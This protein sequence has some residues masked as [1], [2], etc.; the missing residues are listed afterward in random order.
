M[1]VKK[2]PDQ[3]VVFKS[4]CAIVKKSPKFRQAADPCHPE[5]YIHTFQI[6][7]PNY[8]IEGKKFGQR[9]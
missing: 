9:R 3:L 1:K 6:Y 5:C 7:V 2:A 8:K 4:H